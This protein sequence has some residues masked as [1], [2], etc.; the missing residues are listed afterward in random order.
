[1]SEWIL[2]EKMTSRERAIK[3]AKA[4]K[5]LRASHRYSAEEL[6]EESKLAYEEQLKKKEFEN[7]RK[8]K[9]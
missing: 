2:S 4:N 1:M 6:I 7:K 8:N 9:K 5:M 3:D